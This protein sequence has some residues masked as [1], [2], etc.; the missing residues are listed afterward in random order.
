MPV[1]SARLANKACGGHS[2]IVGSFAA[3]APA[4]PEAGSSILYLALTRL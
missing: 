2:A 1:S 4:P 3:P